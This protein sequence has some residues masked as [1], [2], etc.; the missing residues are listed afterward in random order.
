[1]FLLG[2]REPFHQA[3]LVNM[4]NAP[5]ALAW[6]EQRF[7]ITPLPSAD[8]TGVYVEATVI[9]A[10]VGFELGVVHNVRW[11]IHKQ[12]RDYRLSHSVAFTADV[13]AGQRK[14]PR[15]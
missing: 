1:V 12:T 2:M 9:A 15:D 3:V 10:G 7:G 13:A 11:R 4:F 6:M 8:P 14:R 5:V